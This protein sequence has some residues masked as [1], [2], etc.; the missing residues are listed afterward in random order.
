MGMS[1]IINWVQSWVNRGGFQLDALYHTSRIKRSLEREIFL[2][3]AFVES[4]DTAIDI[5]ANIGL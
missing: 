3:N 5:G 4:R 2:A 1:S